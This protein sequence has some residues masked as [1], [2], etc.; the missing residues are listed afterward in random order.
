[1]TTPAYVAYVVL[2]DDLAIMAALI[3]GLHQALARSDWPVKERA[4][5]LRKTSLILIAWY[6]A[7]FTLSWFEFFRGAADRIPAIELGVFVPIIVGTVALWRSETLSRILDAVPQSW[8]VG[9]QAYRTI[10]VIFLILLG[11][12]RLPSEFALPAGI[13]DVL[14]G[15]T[16]PVVALVYANGG[17]SRELLVRAWNTFGI[18]DL[19]VAVGTGFMTSPS[20][21]QLL[22][23]QA[24]NELI[25]AFPLVMIPVFAVPISILLHLLSLMKLRRTRVQKTASRSTVPARAY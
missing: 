15:V 22:S 11:L 16:A 24:P 6:G 7:T 5:V 20:P 8:L 12:G 17:K 4:S 1:M 19:I 18:L 13:G 23:T 14:V 2:G 10:G 25:G 9:V 3:F 21:L